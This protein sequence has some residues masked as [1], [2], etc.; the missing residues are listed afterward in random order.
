MEFLISHPRSTPEEIA[1][2]LRLA[3]GSVTAAL[4]TLLDEL[5]AVRVNRTPSRWSASPPRPAMHAL[6]ARR[7]VALADLELLTEEFH[8]AYQATTGRWFGSDQFEVLD[9]PEQVTARYTHLVR[10]ARTEV[11]HLAMP[12][13]VATASA[14]PDRLNAQEAVIRKGVRFRSV[15]DAGTFDDPLS[16]ETAR[17]GS[18]IGG[19]IRL[20]T[21]LPMKLVM[22]DGAAAFMPL[23]SG[24]PE[25]ATLLVHSPTLLYVLSILFEQLWERG[26]P[27]RG[28]GTSA[29]PAEEPAEPV[30]D[31]RGL[32]VLRLLSLGMKD[33]VI[34]RALGVSRRTVQQDISDI[35][36]LLGA[37]TRFQVA[38]FAQQRGWLPAPLLPV[39]GFGRGRRNGLVAGQ[40]DQPVIVIGVQDLDAGARLGDGTGDRAQLARGFLVEAASQHLSDRRDRYPGRG[41]RAPRL[42]AVLDQEVGDRPPVHG[43]HAAALDADPRLAER[44]PHHCQRVGSAAE[45]DGQIK[46]GISFCR[47]SAGRRPA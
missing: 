15:Y 30:P 41:Q 26:T 33:D 22:F 12:P 47:A 17:R 37:R 32:E 35:S 14:V 3:A 39:P 19:E 20:S 44:L 28:E 9:T 38:L 13:Y 7:R 45:L 36:A 16:L 6:L 46:H 21:G 23:R 2:V 43:E 11:L 42:M 40:Q 29:A 31:R 8:E 27:W 10:A 4:A 18:E 24:D 34:A 5:L 1:A 25:A